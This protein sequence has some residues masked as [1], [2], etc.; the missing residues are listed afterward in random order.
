MPAI[1]SVCGDMSRQHGITVE[2]R[3][4]QVPGTIDAAVSLYAYRIVQEALHNVVKH[5]GASQARVELT[6][7]GVALELV[8]A[9]EGRG[10]DP[11]TPGLAGLGLLSMRER[12]KLLDGE[13]GIRSKPGTGTR[14]DVRIPF[15]APARNRR[16][17]DGQRSA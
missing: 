14:L 13:I 6:G 10:F 15:T 11:D 9:D 5:S 1:R 7:S 8:V 2:F 16:A 3:D 12:V 17:A 4:E